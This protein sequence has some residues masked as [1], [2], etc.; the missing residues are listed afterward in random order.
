MGRPRRDSNKSDPG[1][2]AGNVYNA[3]VAAAAQQQKLLSAE[4]E[5]APTLSA[6]VST[7]TP[8]LD[9]VSVLVSTEKQNQ[10]DPMMIIQT[11][12][13]SQTTSI[14]N[15]QNIPASQTS[16]N[17]HR[18]SLSISELVSLASQARSKDRTGN[19]NRQPVG[20]MS[21][22][23]T[24]AALN[25]LNLP[26]T[27]RATLEKAESPILNALIPLIRQKLAAK[28]AA[29]NRRFSAVDLDGVQADSSIIDSRRLSSSSRSEDHRISH[30]L[31]ERKRRKEMKDVFDNL[32]D[33]LPPGVPKSSKWEILNEASTT[34]DNLLA[35]EQALLHQ[36]NQLL[37]QINDSSR[38]D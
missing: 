34:I 20:H 27:L 9:A 28:T 32:K 2:T 26:D 6:G 18:R 38:D 3:S 12:S 10:D 37:K 8:E 24:V 33:A 19:L 4:E 21:G 22:S 25:N 11:I 1:S 36:R 5:E 23:A 17:I 13:S 35:Q 31:A 30:K 7:L 29:S 15:S 14:Q 16:P